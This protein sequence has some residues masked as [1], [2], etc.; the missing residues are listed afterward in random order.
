M[1]GISM[2]FAVYFLRFLLV[3]KFFGFVCKLVVYVFACSF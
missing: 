3:Q 1:E 2:Q